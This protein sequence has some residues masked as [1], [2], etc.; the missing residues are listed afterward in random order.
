MTIS[1]THKIKIIK[2]FGLSINNTGATEVQ[3]ALLTANI[4]K[5]QYHFKTN[6]NDF[7]SRRGLMGMVNKRRKLLIYLKN[8]DKDNYLSLI[9][10][11]KIR[12]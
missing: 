1:F 11:L 10:N 5:L 2:N 9:K 7:H 4:I 8:K 12:R 6:K 3:I